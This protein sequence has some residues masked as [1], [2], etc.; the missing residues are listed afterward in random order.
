MSEVTPDTDGRGGLSRRAAA[1]LAGIGYLVIFGLSLFANF[2][3]REALIDRDDAAATAEN[4]A[5]AEALFRAGM[6]AFLVV[7]VLD[8][9]IAWALYVFF[10]TTDRDLS[11]LTAWFRLVYTVFLGVALISSFMVVGL[12]SDDRHL[13]A[14]DADQI[15]AQVLFS[16]DAFD[17]AWVIGLACFGVH[18]VLLGVLV[19][20]ST[21]IPN[22]I[23]VLLVLAGLGYIT[24]TVARAVLTSYD[25]YAGVLLAIVAVPSIIGEYAF[26]LWLLLRGAREPDGEPALAG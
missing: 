24:D 12:L 15:D 19:F 17:Y 7:F 22:L 6:V 3:A 25:D 20:R 13:G 5:D 1:R 2:V 21:P 16:L 10:R 14:F 23:G 11:L 26:T 9:A 4:I 18:L 8:V